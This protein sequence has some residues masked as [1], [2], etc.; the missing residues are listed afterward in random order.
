MTLLK[1]T[2]RV[3]AGW[4]CIALGLAVIVLMGLGVF[5]PGAGLASSPALVSLLPSIS[6]GV[7]IA[8]VGVWL[9]ATRSK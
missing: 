8:A 1:R 9:I 2:A 3:L 7:A 5:A 6:F 4:L